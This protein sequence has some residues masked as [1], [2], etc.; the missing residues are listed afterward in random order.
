MSQVLEPATSK[1]LEKASISSSRPSGEGVPGNEDLPA[2]LPANGGDVLGN[3]VRMQ[4][5]DLRFCEGGAKPS[6]A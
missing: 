4:G 3:L 1:S 6:S 2:S 5:P